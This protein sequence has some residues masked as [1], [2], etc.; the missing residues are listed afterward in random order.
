MNLRRKRAYKVAERN[1]MNL[2]SQG[3]HLSDARIIV[4]LAERECENV[5]NS[6]D[7][8]PWSLPIKV[9][10]QPILTRISFFCV[11]Q[12]LPLHPPWLPAPVE[13]CTLLL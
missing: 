13:V 4:D 3:F 11:S 1:A 2:G 5:C 10:M 7:G 9:V 6:K 12:P 8:T